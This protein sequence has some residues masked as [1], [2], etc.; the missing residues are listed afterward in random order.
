MSFTLLDQV[1]FGKFKS[2]HKTNV[3]F[4]GI[5]LRASM[6][7]QKSD[8]YNRDTGSLS[9]IQHIYLNI[10]VTVVGLKTNTRKFYIKLIKNNQIMANA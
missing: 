8:V 6:H 7:S 2:P 4:Y 9:I 10:T 1:I 3:D 5:G